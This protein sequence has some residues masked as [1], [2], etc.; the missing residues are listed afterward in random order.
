VIAVHSPLRLGLFL[1]AGQHPDM[2]QTQALAGA[3]EAALAAE[4]AGLDSVWIA[5]HHFITYGICPSAITFAANILGRTRRIDVGTAVCMLANRHPLALAEETCLLD[6]LN[7]SWEFMLHDR[8]PP[9]Q[10][11]G[12]VRMGYRSATAPWP[13]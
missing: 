9:Q 4:R 12:R 5:E 6:Q 7:A 3:V 11:A 2:T 1:L 13:V 10:A 8:V